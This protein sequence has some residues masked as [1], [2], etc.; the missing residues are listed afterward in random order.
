MHGKKEL[1]K[2]LAADIKKRLG[3]INKE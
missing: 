3:L 2:G 1:P